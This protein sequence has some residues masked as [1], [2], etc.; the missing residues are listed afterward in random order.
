MRKRSFR[1]YAVGAALTFVS[2]L[3]VAA[4]SAQPA[5]ATPTSCETY[6]VGAPVHQFEVYCD[7][8]S[9]Q[10]RAAIHCG[11]AIGSSYWRYGAWQGTWHKGS[12]A[13]CDTGI[14]QTGA[15]SYH[16]EYK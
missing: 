7:A 12:F 10:W 3:G 1:F 8:G 11:R 5:L 6:A 13:F 4:A 14:N 16:A 9:G 15:M 2:A